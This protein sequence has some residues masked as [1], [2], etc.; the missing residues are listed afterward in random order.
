[1][2]PKSK[3]N[4]K[5]HKKKIVSSVHPYVESVQSKLSTTQEHYNKLEEYEN[6]RQ[7]TTEELAEKQK[8]KTTMEAYEDLLLDYNATSTK[9]KLRS[10]QD[11]E[12][13]EVRHRNEAQILELLNLFYLV[14]VG[15]L[16]T[17]DPI[18]FPNKE[19]LLRAAMDA[20]DQMLGAS[21]YCKVHRSFQV[22]LRKKDHITATLKKLE[23]GSNELIMEGISFK[24]IKDFMQH[25]WDY[26]T[27]V[28]E[29]GEDADDKE[30]HEESNL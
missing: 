23:T 11:R 28:H 29:E 13:H 1:M 26:A 10:Y 18:D 12:A 22:R 27:C 16:G 30:N 6:T 25:I 8:L 14:R 20:C 15:S 2:R 7:L 4:R 24:Q 5:M 19:S 3:P 17:F 9:A 21:I